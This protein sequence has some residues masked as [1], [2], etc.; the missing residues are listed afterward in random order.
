MID[1]LLQVRSNRNNSDCFNL[2]TG[3][4]TI[5]SDGISQNVVNQSTIREIKK[6][7]NG[8][9]IIGFSAVNIYDGKPILP[10]QTPILANQAY[11]AVIKLKTTGEIDN[12]FFNYG[13]TSLSG[14]S[15]QSVTSIEETTDGKYIIGG[16]FNSYSGISY[17]NII[18]LNSNGTID[19]TF[20]IGTGFDGIVGDIELQ[21]DGKIIVTGNF[22]SYSGVSKNRIV[23]LNSNGT[24]DNTFN[25]G[26][27]FSS[28]AVYD[29][30]IQSDGKIVCVGSFTSYNGSTVGRIIRLNTN[31]S[32]DTTFNS[33]QVG[34]GSPA[35][36]LSVELQSDGKILV[37]GGNITSYN[38][39]SYTN[40]VLFRLNTNG[41][42]DSSF[43]SNVPNSGINGLGPGIS[44]IAIQSNGKIL[45]YSFLYLDIIIGKSRLAA[46]TLNVS[47]S[48]SIN[49]CFNSPVG[50]STTGTFSSSKNFII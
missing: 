13:F 37:G 44:N 41:S 16:N 46:S 31:G 5:Q 30:K 15:D 23:R 35:V 29:S 22:T 40:K 12:S 28:G 38:G 32:I 7:Q 50:I 49:R 36:M 14:T 21:S 33:G 47:L 11:P 3:F 34:F 9:L 24:I 1:T 27:G 20:N 25:I 45:S 42:I 17:N 26:T 19:N 10:F 43:M 8:S 39:I 2:G 48:T 6:T 4:K 18:K